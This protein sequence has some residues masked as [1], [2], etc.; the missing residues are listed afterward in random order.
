MNYFPE[1]TDLL[2][3]A[4][5]SIDP[6]KLQEHSGDKW[7][8]SHSPDVDGEP[9]T[10]KQVPLLLQ[11]AQQK[12]IAVT[13]RGAGYGYVAGGVTEPGGISLSLT[14]MNELQEDEV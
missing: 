2:G 1:L 10:T 7:V 13:P 9:E 12:R 14:R 6:R 3:A 5:V 4:A 11:F 8:A